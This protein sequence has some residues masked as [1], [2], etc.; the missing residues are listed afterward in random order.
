MAEE[1]Y[2]VHL[3]DDVMGIA[4]DISIQCKHCATHCYPMTLPKKSSR[5]QKKNT[6][7]E[8]NLMA[9]LLPFITGVGPLMAMLLPFIMGVGSTELETILSMQGLP[10][11]KHYQRTLRRWQPTIAEDNCNIREGD[12]TCNGGRDQ[13][14]YCC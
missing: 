10:N 5:G 9:M 12:E 13:G 11:S 8:E 7:A 4:S 2:K 1:K 3:T 6:D 14:N